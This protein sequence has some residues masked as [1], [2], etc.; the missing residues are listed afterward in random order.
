MEKEEYRVTYELE[1]RYWWHVGLRRAVI[2]FITKALNGRQS[3]KILDAG[4][5][6]GALLMEL[7]NYHDKVGLDISPEALKFCQQRKLQKLVQGSIMQIPFQGNRFDLIASIDVI[8]HRAVD[9]DMVALKEFRRVLN[10]GGKLILHLPAFD[11][12]QSS[13]DIAIHTRH[14]YTK[15]ELKSKL[16]SAGFKVDSITYRNFLLFPFL[17]IIRLWGKF[18]SQ[19]G[20]L[21]SDLRE[22]PQFVNTGLTII[23]AL[24]EHLMRRVDLPFGLSIFCMARK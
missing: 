6:T 22:L 23:M 20:Q 15:G 5:G 3:Q 7:R 14:R 19:R 8:Y 1:G 16:E 18:K 4:C 17:A 9:D 21:K 2:S 11:F 24:E 13:H 12:L 10:D